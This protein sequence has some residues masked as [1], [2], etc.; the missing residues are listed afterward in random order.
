LKL[1]WDVSTFRYDANFYL[2]AAHRGL[3]GPNITVKEA[4]ALEIAQLTELW[5]QYGNL[6]EIWLDGGFTPTIQ[7]ST[8]TR[9]LNPIMGLSSV[10]CEGLAWKDIQF[11]SR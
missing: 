3:K 9:T 10:L 4:E 2:G 6:T 1:T 8:L 5:T 7:A 11:D